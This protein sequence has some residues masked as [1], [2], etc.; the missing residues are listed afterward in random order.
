VSTTIFGRAFDKG[1]RAVIHDRLRWRYSN[2][3]EPQSEGE[4]KSS[5]DTTGMEVPKV[6]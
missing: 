5:V 2:T 1:A 4:W 6:K 3:S